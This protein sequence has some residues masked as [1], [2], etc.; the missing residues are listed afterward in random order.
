MNDGV[1][2]ITGLSAS[3]KTTLAK[4]LAELLKAS[5]SSHVLLDGDELRKCFNAQQ[6]YSK[7]E[8][9]SLSYNYSRI[10][11]MI[12]E[13][14]IIVVI[15]VV[16]LF[17]EVHIWNRQN[18]NNYFEVFLNTPKKELER[19]D[20]KKI[21]KKFRQGEINNVSGYDLEVDYPNNPDFL[22]DFEPSKSSEEVA[23]EVFHNFMNYKKLR[24]TIDN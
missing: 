16:A 15:A 6:Q 11:K 18:I 14:N 5:N 8:R 4:N 3:G 10:S 17:E 20:P 1:I 21:Y 12:S 23:K 2:W 9:L 24:T 22:V 13:Q 7:K 19:R